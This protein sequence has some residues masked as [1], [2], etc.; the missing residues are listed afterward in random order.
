ME[1][2]RPI[3]IAGASGG[4][5]IITGTLQCILNCLLHDMSPGRAVAAPRFHHQWLPDVLQFEERW[6]DEET[7]AA[8]QEIGHPIGRRDEIGVVQLIRV[9][10]D[11]VGAASDPRKGGKPAGY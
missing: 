4:P 6:T 7:V 3:V 9:D 8:L 10:S 11:G 2:G 5:R 1:A